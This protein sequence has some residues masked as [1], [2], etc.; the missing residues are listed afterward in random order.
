[1]IFPIYRPRWR[2]IQAIP[3]C[4]I[5]RSPSLSYVLPHSQAEIEETS[6]DCHYVVPYSQAEVEEETSAVLA[7]QAEDVDMAELLAACVDSDS[8]DM[9]GGATQNRSE[10]GVQR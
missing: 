4:P 5:I 2:R 3:I 9:G 8:D 6:T 7:S 1:M 10:G